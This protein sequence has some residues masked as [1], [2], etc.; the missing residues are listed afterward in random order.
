MSFI[1]KITRHSFPLCE[2]VTKK[3]NIIIIIIIIVVVV[4]VVVV[5][6]IIQGVALS[7]RRNRSLHALHNFLSFAMRLQVGPTYRIKSL[8]HLVLGRPRGLLCPRGIHSVT[9][10]IH[11]LSCLLA[12]YPTHLCLLSLMF[13]IMSVTPFCFRIQFV[14]FLSFRV[15]PSMILSIFLWV[16]TRSHSHMSLLGVHIR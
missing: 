6:I 2:A 1:Q 7:P 14:L 8:H 9:L 5:I 11:L 12:T 15:T 3:S 4:V 10:I 13:L 16:V